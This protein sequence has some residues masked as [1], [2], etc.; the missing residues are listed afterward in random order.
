M[1]VDS[2]GQSPSCSWSRSKQDCLNAFS[3]TLR[4]SGTFLQSLKALGP[5]VHPR[6]LE[7]RLV[8]NRH[9]ACTDCEQRSRVRQ[10]RALSTFAGTAAKMCEGADVSINFEHFLPIPAVVSDFTDALDFLKQDEPKLFEFLQPAKTPRLSFRTSSACSC[11][12]IPVG[13]GARCAIAGG[14]LYRS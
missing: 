9:V 7:F 5:D 6:K 10:R 12:T 4:A 3:P 2:G 1:L 8:V 13:Q 11:R 14:S